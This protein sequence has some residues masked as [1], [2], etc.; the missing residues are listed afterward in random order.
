MDKKI[1]NAIIISVILFT[2][3]IALRMFAKQ[4]GL[5]IIL[6]SI[7]VFIIG[8]VGTTVKRGFLLSFV[9]GFIFT[10]VNTMIFSPDF[11]KALGNSSVAM[12]FVLLTLIN[13]AIGGVLGAIGGLFG[14][15]ILK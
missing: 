1:I 5:Q 3:G 9:L 15:R 7:M 13:S 14:K 10:F 12:A 11:L 4:E 2:L 8:F 6:Y